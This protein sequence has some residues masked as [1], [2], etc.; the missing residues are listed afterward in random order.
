MARILFTQLCFERGGCRVIRLIV[1]YPFFWCRGKPNRGI[2]RLESADDRL[3]G[4]APP[5]VPLGQ[6]LPGPPQGATA[7]GLKPHVRAVLTL[8]QRA[9]L[10]LWG[11]RGM[12]GTARKNQRLPDAIRRL[13]EVTIAA[14]LGAIGPGVDALMETRQRHG[15]S[16]V[17]GGSLTEQFK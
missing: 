7:T 9:V 8:P 2:E 14:E 4:G 5:L 16:G 12:L 10:D 1:S 6:I 11:I 3:A 13:D 17:I 15:C